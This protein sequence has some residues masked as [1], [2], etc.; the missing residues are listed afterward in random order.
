MKRQEF[1]E[2]L[3]AEHRMFG[4]KNLI[5]LDK[6]GF[7][8][9]CNRGSAWVTKGQKILGLVSGKRKRRTNLLWLSAMA[10][11]ATK[12]NGWRQCCFKDRAMRSFLKCGL[13]NV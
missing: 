6:T 8:A 13:R 11:K 9:H 12:K 1:L 10:E 4:F 3:K 2:K 5:Y 7:D